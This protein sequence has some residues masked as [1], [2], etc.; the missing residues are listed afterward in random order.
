MKRRADAA[1]GRH[2]LAVGLAIAATAGL[3]VGLAVAGWYPT[4]LVWGAK[5]SWFGQLAAGSL[6]A[7]SIALFLLIRLRFAQWEI[8]RD[9]RF[10]LPEGVDGLTGLANRA[11]FNRAVDEILLGAT[12]P[13]RVTLLLLDLDS[14]KE[15]NDT[16]GHHA[17]DAVLMEVGRRLRFVCGP[18][19]IAGRLGGDEFAVLMAGAAAEDA[20]TAC[21]LIIDAVR[22]PIA[23]DGQTLSVGVSIGFVV[24]DEPAATRD[25]L[26]RRADRALYTAKGQ[27]KNCAVAFDADMDRDASQRRFLEREL[28]GAIIAGEIGIEVQ[29][30]YS[31]DGE[32]VVGAEALARWRH[33]YRGRMMPADFIPLAESTGLIHQLGR[34]V[35]SKACAAAANWGDLFVSVNVSPIQMRRPDFVA[36]VGEVLAETGLEP[37]RLTLEITEGVLIE[38]PDKALRMTA[39]IRAL[40]VQIALDDFGA[41]FSSLSYLRKF[42][43]DKLK[44]DRSFVTDLDSGAEAATILHCVVNLGRALGLKVIAEGVEL[45]SHAGFLRAAGCHQMQGYLFGHPMPLAAFEA[46][47]VARTAHQTVA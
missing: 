15:V 23:S 17:G 43:L 3:T 6:I 41:G 26:M 39:E 31:A 1:L 29:P 44:I 24:S 30:I 28:R 4:R 47:H 2:V 32:T 10:L 13:S 19:Q 18:D 9:A 22:K 34:S 27:G 8:I 25:D 36:M 33:S 35:L 42:P 11:A 14:F 45:A 38:D 37:A 7:A 21:R 40:G 16:Y 46:R 5:E 20:A 12:A